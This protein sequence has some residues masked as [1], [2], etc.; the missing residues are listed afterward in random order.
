MYSNYILPYYCMYVI[1]SNHDLSPFLAPS[2]K[3]VGLVPLNIPGYSQNELTW[4]PGV[5]G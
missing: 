3:S 5:R 4:A 2:Q 1:L